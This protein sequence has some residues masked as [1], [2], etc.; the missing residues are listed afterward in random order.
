MQASM[1]EIQANMQANIAVEEAQARFDIASQ[2]VNH[3]YN[4][5]EMYTQA[6]L[7]GKE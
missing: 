7:K 2:E 5:D 4:M 6:R 1:S 3:E